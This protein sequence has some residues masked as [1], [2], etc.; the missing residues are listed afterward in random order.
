MIS[1]SSIHSDLVKLIHIHEQRAL[2]AL[3][4]LPLQD[5]VG[6]DK[7]T[8]NRCDQESRPQNCEIGW[9][10][11]RCTADAFTAGSAAAV[12][13]PRAGC[14]VLAE[15]AAG[16]ARVAACGVNKPAG[17]GVFGTISDRVS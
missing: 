10:R 5:P 7:D 12:K 4:D 1:Q 17:N 16:A 2:R 14:V 3:V 15:A 9:L 13:V 6:S 8:C 11:R